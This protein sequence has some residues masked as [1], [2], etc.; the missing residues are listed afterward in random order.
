MFIGYVVLTDRGEE[1]V[2]I[3][4][5]LSRRLREHKAKGP[6]KGLV[7]KVLLRVELE[8]R[9]T[10]GCWEIE[11]IA[12]RGGPEKLLNTSLG[13]HGGRR[14][15]VSQA[16]RDH[17]SRLA[18][19]RQADPEFRRKMSEACKAAWANPM[20][21]RRQS[22]AARKACA[23]DGTKKRRSEAQ[24]K[25]WADPKVRQRRIDGIKADRCDPAKAKQRSQAAKKAWE[26]R[27]MK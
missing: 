20:L 1:Y 17:L 13:G 5:D 2:G 27:R 11:Q 25:L 19:D 8:D 10:A 6:L 18:S 24:K 3:T 16:E 26:K 7:L 22:E 4:N 15:V 23:T 21:R 12:A 14:R 9:E